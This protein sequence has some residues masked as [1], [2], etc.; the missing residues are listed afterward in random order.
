MLR[1]LTFVISHFSEKARWTLDLSGLD[2]SERYLLPGPHMLVT[3]RLALR[4]V[5]ADPAARDRSCRLRDILDYVE[6]QIGVTRLAAAPRSREC[7]RLETW[8]TR[9]SPG[10]QQILYDKLLKGR[11]S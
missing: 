9:R 6:Q 4:N 5:R 8:S 7:A 11:S 2:Y 1:L 3:R 10:I